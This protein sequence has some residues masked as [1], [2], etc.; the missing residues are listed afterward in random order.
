MTEIPCGYRGGWRITETS[1]WD[2]D[3]R[4]IPGPAPALSDGPCRPTANRRRS[5]R[6]G[7]ADEVRERMK[8]M[9]GDAGPGGFIAR[10]LGRELGL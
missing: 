10:I 4:D 3:G 1:Q 5:E 7:A 2:N 6:S 8:K 9:E